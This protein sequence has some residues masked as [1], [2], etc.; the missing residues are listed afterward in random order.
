[1]SESPFIER[2]FELE[3]G[4]LTVRFYQPQPAPEGGFGC[5]W[6]IDWPDGP[7]TAVIFGLDGIQALMLS[8]RNAH[9]RLADSEAYRAGKLT[10]LEGTDLDL[11]L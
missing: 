10:W 11:T 3:S 6:T 5:R 1:M 9:G 2:V 7:A 8:M 4:L